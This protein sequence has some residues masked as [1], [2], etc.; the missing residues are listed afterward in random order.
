MRMRT[1]PRQRVPPQSALPWTCSRLS[2]RMMTRAMRRRRRRRFAHPRTS[3]SPRDRLLMAGNTESTKITQTAVGALRC[4]RSPIVEASEPGAIGRA[5][6]LSLRTTMNGLQPERETGRPHGGVRRRRRTKRMTRRAQ[7]APWP[8]GCVAGTPTSASTS[9]TRF[10]CPCG[11]HPPLRP[12]LQLAVHR[13]TLS[14][15]RTLR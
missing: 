11:S 1:S 6:G 15:C 3:N 14:H 13:D 5:R 9:T 4:L 10:T 7:T 12:D 8:R 2:L